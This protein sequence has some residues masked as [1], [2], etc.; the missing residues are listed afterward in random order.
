MTYT[1]TPTINIIKTTVKMELLTDD[2]TDGNSLNTKWNKSSGT[3]VAWALDS[4][5]VECLPAY[6]ALVSTNKYDLTGSHFFAQMMNV[7]TGATRET[8][9]QLL[10]NGNSANQYAIYVTG[11]TG[12]NFQ[13]RKT[14]GGSHTVVNSIPY[15]PI[16]HAWWRI[17]ENTGGLNGN[18]IFE[19]SPDGAT[20]TVFGAASVFEFQVTDMQ[21]NIISGYY[22]TET[23]GWVNV[24]NVNIAGIPPVGGPV[25]LAGSASG[26]STTTA[27]LARAVPLVGTAD[28]ITSTTGTQQVVARA[29]AGS[30]S[31]TS[32]ATGTLDTAGVTVPSFP[33]T[34]ALED[35]GQR[36]TEDGT[37]RALRELRPRW[38]GPGR[39]QH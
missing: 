39:R 38:A 33:G 19:H 11:N 20:W 23:T 34:R 10:A 21:V 30:S 22:G 5:M 9:I 12:N 18:I 32:T 3:G 29:L 7:P 25:D 16:T 17:R 27:A 2:F 24:D 31:A 14:V 26:T 1:V 13:C 4:M 8:F 6:P 15:D 35:D 28:G 37:Y 36:N